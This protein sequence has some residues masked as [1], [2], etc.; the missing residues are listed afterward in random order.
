MAEPM[1]LTRFLIEELTGVDRNATEG[2]GLAPREVRNMHF[3]RRGG[4]VVFGGRRGDRF[5][6]AL[7]GTPL[8][9]D[10]GRLVLFDD[11][12]LW[13]DDRAEPIDFAPFNLER[14]TLVP[15]VG[16]LSRFTRVGEDYAGAAYYLDRDDALT[17]GPVPTGIT[18]SL[19]AGSEVPTGDYF[20]L[21][22]LEAPTV[23]GLLS[24]ETIV[25]PTVNVTSSS[26]AGAIIL[27]LDSVLP[28]GHV[29]RFY[30]RRTAQTT[31]DNFAVRVSNG[32]LLVTARLE[33]VTPFVE[34]ADV[35]MNFAPGRV[36]PHLG[37]VWGQSSLKPFAGYFS[38]A[39]FVVVGGHLLRPQG[40][41]L[42]TVTHSAP[43]T[44]VNA[45]MRAFNDRIDIDLRRLYVRRTS[46]TAPIAVDLFDVRE[47]ATPARRVFARLTWQPGVTT[48]TVDLF[49]ATGTSAFTLHRL[50]SIAI[51]TGL[52]LG[53][54][55]GSELTI[56]N[57]LLS[58]RLGTIA[59]QGSTGRINSTVAVDLIRPAGT[60]SEVRTIQALPAPSARLPA[61]ADEPE[62]STYRQT[63][64]GGATLSAWTNPAHFVVDSVDAN[65][66]VQA[67]IQVRSGGPGLYAG[68]T[69]SEPR[70]IETVD[71]SVTYDID[72]TSLTSLTLVA[73]GPDGNVNITVSTSAF[74][75]TVNIGRR[76]TGLSVAGPSFIFPAP[77]GQP[78]PVHTLRIRQLRPHGSRANA[79]SGWSAWVGG[80][81]Q[82]LSLGAIPSAFTSGLN[83]GARDMQARAITA[84]RLATDQADGRI[85]DYTPPGTTWVSLAT[86]E[87]WT[88]TSA[89]YMV[90]ETQSFEAP[91]EA[92]IARPETTLVYSEV[93]SVNRGSVENFLELRPIS[94]SGI[95]ALASTPAGLVVFMENETFLVRGDPLSPDFSAQRLSGTLGNDQNV[96]PGRLGGVVFPIYKGQV[97]AIALGMGDVDFGSGIDNISLPVWKPE[98]PF[99]QVVGEPQTNH[100]VC[101][102]QSGRIYRYD[103]TRQAWFNDPFD[104]DDSDASEGGNGVRFILPAAF[105]QT[106]GSRYLVGEELQVMDLHGQDLPRVSWGNLDVGDKHTDKLWRRVEV[107]TNREYVGPPLLEFIVR[108]NGSQAAAFIQLEGDFDA[109][110]ALEGGGS[111]LTLERT[112][113]VVG[114]STGDGRWVFSLRRGRVGA[115]MDMR[116]I[117]RDFTRNDVLEAPLAIEVARR[118]R[119]RGRVR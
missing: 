118:S 19:T 58:V 29:V 46:T 8:A 96:V 1:G 98:D 33:G 90:T 72:G 13:V 22:T 14:L 107:A 74:A 85:L 9:W 6:A 82:I 49:V 84:A 101:L 86:G 17:I 66:Y 15:G 116:L 26:G 70:Y 88:A 7:P 55:N 102:T 83:S 69:F 59:Q 81:A 103:A 117:L 65:R 105:D 34:T 3:D 2:E 20:F 79:W 38:A 68:I 97:Y 91:D 78:V 75:Q 60:V 71:V 76:V 54:A 47:G 113:Q 25:V 64:D 52:A 5:G 44:L 31:Y 21:V 99:V 114:V 36:E 109:P 10:E 39:S 92:V 73:F 32:E 62:N 63:T 28:P 89:D 27:E 67:T 77:I 57:N 45:M 111:M 43:A 51:P 94:S 37:R 30:Y 93:G 100:I 80:G 56:T 35:K 119:P 61:V 4:L 40:V 24:Y 53:T 87:T 110:L 106:Y 23:N 18:T 112:N 115:V 12:Q 108:G 42:S 41:G 16:L 104:L 50:A 95:T 11:L 48:P